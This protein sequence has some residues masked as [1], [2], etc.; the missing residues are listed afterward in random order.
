MRSEDCWGM[1]K[2]KLPI[3]EISA[4]PYKNLSA[5][6]MR[7]QHCV[8]YSGWHVVKFCDGS[9]YFI[10]DVYFPCHLSGVSVETA[11]KSTARRILVKF[12]YWTLEKRLPLD[13]LWR[14]TMTVQSFLSVSQSWMT[15]YSNHKVRNWRRR[16]WSFIPAT[17]K[18]I[19]RTY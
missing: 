7:N 9:T 17:I 11:W 6:T 12:I 3:E 4:E 5:V 19:C 10:L 16:Y 1:Q 8:S 18:P 15:D 14:A 13:D 2:S